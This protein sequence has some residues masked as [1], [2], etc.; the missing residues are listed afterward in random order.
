MSVRVSLVVVF[1][2]VVCHVHAQSVTYDKAPQ[3]PGGNEALQ[4]YLTEKL[5]YPDKAKQ[6][7]IEGQVMV[8]FTVNDKGR[9]GDIRILKHAHALLDSEAVRVV[10]T[11]PRWQPATKGKNAVAAPVALPLTFKMNNAAPAGKK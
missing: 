4:R 2:S 6:K 9:V 11:M 3:Y 10:R 7:S 8:G 5:V 1:M